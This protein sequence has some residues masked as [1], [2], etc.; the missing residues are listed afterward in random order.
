MTELTQ[1]QNQYLHEVHSVSIMSIG[2]LEGSFQHGYGGED[3]GIKRKN[4]ALSDSTADAPNRKHMGGYTAK[5]SHLWGE[6]EENI[7]CD[8][9]SMDDGEVEEEEIIDTGDNGNKSSDSDTTSESEEDNS[10]SDRSEEESNDETSRISVSRDNFLTMLTNL[11]GEG[12][13]LF[14]SWEPG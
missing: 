12:A 4:S 7:G 9:K 11:A 5:T 14:K 1:K 2:S 6:I 10:F 8:N 13:S 3:S